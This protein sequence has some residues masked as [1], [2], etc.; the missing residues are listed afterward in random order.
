MICVEV[1][2]DHNALNRRYCSSDYVPDVR[3]ELSNGD[4][5][6]PN[7]LCGLCLTIPVRD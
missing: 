7:V 4:F 2:P 1:A 3:Q 5:T 6:L